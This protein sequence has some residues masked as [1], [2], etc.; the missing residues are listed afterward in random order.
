MLAVA[1]QAYDLPALCVLAV[2]LAA[3]SALLGEWARAWAALRSLRLLL[4]A[5]LIVHIG[6]TPGPPLF[7]AL[8]GLSRDGALLGLHRALLLVD[9]VLGVALLLSG[10]SPESLAAA[11]PLGLLGEPGRAFA[12]Q[13]ALCL[14][15]VTDSRTRLAGLRGEG[16]IVDGLARWGLAL[17]RTALTAVPSPSLPPAPP[18][19]PT[20]WG[21]LA[22]AAAAL[23]LLGYWA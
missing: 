2:G 10:L 19:R 1:V 5:L 8:P 11:L 12:R 20:H 13:T 22:A 15:A 14:Q 17:E 7:D 6:F 23:S 18:L 3:A 9:M 4:L 16:S 21:L